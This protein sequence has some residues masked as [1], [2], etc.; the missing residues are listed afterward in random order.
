MYRCSPGV[1]ALGAEGSGG[2]NGV[3]RRMV[4]VFTTPAVLE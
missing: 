3:L 4:K 2:L 1:G